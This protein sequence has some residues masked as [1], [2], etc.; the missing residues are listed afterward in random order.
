M[1]L[2][3]LESS[4]PIGE[5][6][7]GW[8]IVTSGVKMY[9]RSDMVLFSHKNYG[10]VVMVIYD[11]DKI[12]VIGAWE[13]AQKLENRITDVLLNGPV[14]TPFVMAFNDLASVKLLPEDLPPGFTAMP[15]S[16]LEVDQASKSELEKSGLRFVGV[17]GLAN[18]K[19]NAEEIVFGYTFQYTDTLGMAIMD[20][21][22]ASN[23]MLD[24]MFPPTPTQRRQPLTITKPIGDR[25]LSTAVM[26][27][28]QT[29]GVRCDVLVFRRGHVG[30]ALFYMYVTGRRQ[31]TV[32]DLAVKLDAKLLDL[33][34]P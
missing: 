18:D 16:E 33:S 13:V 28:T 2:E 6:S 30:A 17:F 19:P 29:G 31:T 1:R 24:I 3:Q 21:L 7:S 8:K 22:L 9:L 11:S 23:V 15:D 12:P 20:Q 25:A 27:M 4:I 14:P 34:T 32:E 26:E 5:M 10:G